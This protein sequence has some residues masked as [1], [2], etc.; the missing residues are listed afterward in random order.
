MRGLI[1][2]LLLSLATSPATAQPHF[3]P[4]IEGGGG[5]PSGL[6][7]HL[8]DMVPLTFG[9]TRASPDVQ[10]LWDTSHT[11]DRFELRVPA[12][13]DVICLDDGTY[14]SCISLAGSNTA[15]SIRNYDDTANGSLYVGSLYAGGAAV[16]VSP[17]GAHTWNGRIH[18][19][20][21]EDAVLEIMNAAEAQGLRLDL[22]TDGV[23]KLY[24]E[25]GGS[26]NLQLSGNLIMA[27]NADFYAQFAAGAIV[28]RNSAQTNQHMTFHTGTNANVIAITA[29]GA[30]GTN[31]GWT[32]QPTPTLVGY[33]DDASGSEW[34][35]IT[36]NGTNPQ[37]RWGSGTTLD[38]SNYTRHHDIPIEAGALGVTSPTLVSIGTFR[39]RRFDASAEEIYVSVEVPTEWNGASD[40]VLSMAAYTESGDVLGNGEVIEFDVDYRSVAEGQPYDNGTATTIHPSVTGG[41]SEPDK[42]LYLITAVVDYDDT[43]QPLADED[44]IGFVINR[45]VGA[46]DTYSGAVDVCRVQLIYT[47][48]ALGT[49]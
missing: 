15:L 1:A 24:D 26:L 11:V 10:L 2:A 39:C 23:A 31:L 35:S 38:L 12:A 3:N 42:G 40:M 28:L 33:S 25:V 34:W 13:S 22:K 48:N 20:S 17:T 47:A 19:K 8:F 29:Y 9:N 16:Q 32:L 27:A 49:H 36:H 46:S 7:L 6:Q 4:G 43:N 5:H 41:G 30:K 45:D 18:L 14:S 44:T 21:S 37:I